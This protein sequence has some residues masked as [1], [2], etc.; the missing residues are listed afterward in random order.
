MN[1]KR[2]WVHINRKR[3]NKSMIRMLDAIE[4]SQHDVDSVREV[5]DILYAWLVYCG[6]KKCYVDAELNHHFK[7][8][9]EDAKNSVNDI[10]LGEE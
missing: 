6:H 9:H 4:V 1:I 3:V 8:I 2:W 7:Q 10:K 5:Y